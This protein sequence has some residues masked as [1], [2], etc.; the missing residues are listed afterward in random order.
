MFNKKEF[1]KKIDTSK[2]LILSIDL[3]N[4]LVNRDKGANYIHPPTLKLLKEL[5]RK[6]KLT[7]IANTGRDIIGFKSFVRDAIPAKNAILG[8]GSVIICGGRKKYL[9]KS[10]ISKSVVKIMTKAVEK[11][12]L[13]F[14]DIYYNSGR[15]I[16]YNNE[17]EQYCD[18]FYGQNPKEWFAGKMPP[19]YY[20]NNINKYL[21]DNI[22]RLEFSIFSKYKKLYT[23]LINKDGKAFVS[24]LKLLKTKAINNTRYSFNRKVFFVPKY[25][26]KLI[27]ARLE[28]SDKFVNKGLGLSAWFKD[29]N[30]KAKDINLIHIG[31]KDS[32]LINDALIKKEIPGSFVVMVGDKCLL[33]NPEVDLYLRGNTDIQ[34]YNF[35]MDFNNYYY[36]KK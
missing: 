12:L 33:N 22:F 26:G 3:D 14:V 11:G 9:N 27:F 20:I 28:I 7:F 16:F 34:L 19:A 35:L 4:T 13:P 30:I 23:E 17:G 2:R 1:L 36:A 10:T 31:D 25:E 21:P 32:G 29:A 8:S 5:I 24:F 6:R 18:L 15:I